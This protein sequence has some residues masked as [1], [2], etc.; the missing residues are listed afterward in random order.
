VV[1]FFCSQCIDNCDKKIRNSDNYIC[2][3]FE[4]YV[5]MC[6]IFHSKIAYV[7]CV[8]RIL[9]FCMAWA[10]LTSIFLLTSGMFSYC[11]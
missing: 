11:N 9:H 4:S 7:A 1:V 10:L 6:A 3:K 2:V 8:G 5:D